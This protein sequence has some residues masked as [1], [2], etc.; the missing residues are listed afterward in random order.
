MTLKTKPR[1]ILDTNLLVSRALTPS[2][3]IAGAVRLIIDHSHLLVSQATMDELAT[4]LVRIQ[5]KGYIKQDETL[6]IIHGYKEVVEWVPIIERIQACRDPKDDKFL[7][8]AVNG[9]AEYLITGDKDLLELQPFK[10]TSILSA[11]DFIDALLP[12]YL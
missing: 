6:R 10:N 7:E 2:S 1:V 8:L 9:N 4:V 3:V 12:T 5:S 11:K